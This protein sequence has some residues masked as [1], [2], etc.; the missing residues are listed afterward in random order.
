MTDESPRPV[1][2]PCQGVAHRGRY[3]TDR[4]PAVAEI[5][6]LLPIVVAITAGIGA[7]G[8]VVLLSEGRGPH[9]APRF[10]RRWCGPLSRSRRHGKRANY[11]LNASANHL[12]AFIFTF[13]A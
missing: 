4:Q 8:L 13:M 10:C 5:V 1:P 3:H 11:P 2:A 7:A 9:H 6:Y 12:A